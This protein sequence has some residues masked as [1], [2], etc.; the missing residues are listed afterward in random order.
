MESTRVGWTSPIE[1]MD[2]LLRVE[3]SE[4]QHQLPQFHEHY[5]R[6]ERLPAELHAQL[7]ALEQRLG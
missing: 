6:F 7:K 3:P 2:E 1:D 5:A 4:W